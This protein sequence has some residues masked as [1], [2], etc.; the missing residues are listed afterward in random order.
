M[1]TK[2]VY[3]TVGNKEEKAEFRAD[4]TLD[5]VRGKCVGT[6]W[7]QRQHYTTG[8]R[9]TVGRPCR[10]STFRYYYRHFF[11]HFFKFIFRREQGINHIKSMSLITFHIKQIMTS[12]HFNVSTCSGK[13]IFYKSS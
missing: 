3:F 10:E 12:M 2:V 13:S 8:E 5:D 1:A 11:L 4:D 7:S 9:Y 6:C